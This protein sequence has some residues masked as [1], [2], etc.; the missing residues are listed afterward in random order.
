MTEGLGHLPMGW[1]PPDG[2]PDTGD[3]WRSAGLTLSRWNMHVGLAAGWWPANHLKVPNIQKNVLPATLPKTHGALVDAVA[4]RLVFRT[5]PAAHRDA[6]LAFL[7]VAAATPLDEDDAAVGW[8]LP[9]LVALILDTPS[10][11]IR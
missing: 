6:V 1:V 3:P 8:R 5:L 2:Y 11:G 9:Y 10:H 7:G 4:K